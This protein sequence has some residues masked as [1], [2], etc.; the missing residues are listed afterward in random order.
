MIN[1]KTI[2]RKKTKKIINESSCN[3]ENKRIV[4]FFSIKKLF[5]YIPLFFVLCS[6]NIFG[7]ISPCTYAL[8]LVLIFLGEN[9]FVCSLSFLCGYMLCGLELN[10]LVFAVCLVVLADISMFVISKKYS[11]VPLYLMLI[12]SLLG[13][14]LFLIFCDK[15]IENFYLS[16][17]EVFANAIFVVSSTK[18]F[19]LLKKRKFNLK[20]NID[21]CVSASLVVAIVFC[22]LESLNIF[23]FDILKFVG[24]CII[25]FGLYILPQNYQFVLP[26]VFGIGASLVGGNLNYIII[27]ESILIFDL[28][29]KHYS[30]IFVATSTFMIDLTLELFFNMSHMPIY[31][32]ILPSLFACL[33]FLCVPNK[34][35]VR[36]QE[37]FFATNDSEVTLKNILNQNKLSVANKLAYTAEVFYE[38]DKDFRKLV[39]GSIDIKTAKNIICS[40]LIKS[41]CEGCSQKARCLKGFGG[42]LK[43]VFEKLI[44]AGFEKGKVTLVDLPSYLT[45]RCSKLNSI[46]LNLN[47]LLGEYKKYNGVM[48]NLDESKVLIAEQ[49]GG[50]SQI[51]SSLSQ[52]ARQVATIDY[53]ME[54]E[55]KENLTYNNIIVSDVVC[56]EKDENT[57]IVSLVLRAVDFDNE[58]LTSVISKVCRKK[59]ALDEYIP[60]NSSQSLYLSY[61]TAPLYSISFGLAQATKGGEEVCGDTH[62]LRRLSGDKFLFVLC[63]G[64]GHGKNANNASELSISLLE[65]FYKAGYNNQTILTSL[66]SLLNLG[67]KDIFSALDVSVV[68]LKS[69]ETD[70]IKQ[71]ASI[72]YIKNNNEISR[73]ET[74]GLPVGILDRIEPKVS[75]TIL[76]PEDTL[77]MF[78][79]GVV[80]AFEDEDKLISFLKDMPSANAQECANSILN[81]AKKLQ[82][83]FPSDDMTVIVGK[84]FY[85]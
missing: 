45:N 69:G 10:E 84:L 53:K 76:S 65:N 6:A 18:F 39:N 21:E 43:N 28:I 55:I 49:L 67:R 30:K 13:G 24:I 68:D 73:I 2:K 77:F 48:T 64:M 26:I 74:S 82:K 31:F 60:N 38:M 3:A 58:K 51:L 34:F 52:D 44:S 17:V 33:I 20:M 75:K 22:G 25:L 78:S 56:F 9:K 71:G 8:F 1:T 66:N 16:I 80:D 23:V 83:N 4:E 63:D 85:A 41:C 14:L 61:K 72:G 32:S 37:K 11:E 62:S 40:E 29:F 36:I 50:I 81:R 42:E 70:F 59:M 27:F 12:F 35:V 7:K 46:I 5:I 47:M 57:S 15:N 79:D 19:R 54:N